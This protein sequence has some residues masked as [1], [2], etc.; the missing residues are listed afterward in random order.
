MSACSASD[1]RWQVSAGPAYK[2]ARTC[3]TNLLDLR[4]AFRHQ[5]QWI[6]IA[7]DMRW[8]TFTREVRS[9]RSP[10]HLAP[11][12]AVAYPSR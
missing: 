6:E 7:E 5:G 2:G 4:R 12:R 10:Y 3:G 1:L 11:R 9:G 8:E